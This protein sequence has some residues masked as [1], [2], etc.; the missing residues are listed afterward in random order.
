MKVKSNTLVKILVPSAL[1][2]AVLI[3]IKSCQPD[4]PVT[5]SRH[6]DLDGAVVFDVDLVD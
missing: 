4:T 1:A 2:L 3:G 5:G 6:V